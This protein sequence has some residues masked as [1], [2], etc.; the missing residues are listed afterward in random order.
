MSEKMEETPEMLQGK[1]E[2]EMWCYECLSRI[3]D[4]KKYVVITE[5]LLE[6]SGDVLCESCFDPETLSQI[7]DNL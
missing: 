1:L 7:R 4:A 6:E 5:D 3:D 2:V